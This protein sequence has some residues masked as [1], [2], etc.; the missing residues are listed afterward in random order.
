MAR[1]LMQEQPGASSQAPLSLT[2]GFPSRNMVTVSFSY[3]FHQH[4][5]WPHAGAH[6]CGIYLPLDDVQDGDVA[7]VGLPVSTC[8]H[9]HVFR[10][11]QSSHHI[12]DCG[13][14]H[15]GH[16]QTSAGVRG[17]GC[18]APL[19]SH[20]PAHAH[21]NQGQ[22]E[23]EALALGTEPHAKLHAGWGNPKVTPQAQPG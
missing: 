16:L 8:G 1:S 21:R 18:A 15:T 11:Q 19:P 22:L 3:H 9:H 4:L 17:S 13:F 10:L 23:G 14:P 12:Q 2:L 7:V 5:K 6:L 20:C